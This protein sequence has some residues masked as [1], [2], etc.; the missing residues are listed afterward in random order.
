MTLW[1]S[2]ENDGHS[3]RGKDFRLLKRLLGDGMIGGILGALVLLLSFL[4]GFCHGNVTG[5]ILREVSARHED[6]R[7]PI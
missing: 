7:R 2:G 1:N 6:S 4:E 3:P 5:V